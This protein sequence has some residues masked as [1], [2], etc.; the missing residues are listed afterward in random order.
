MAIAAYRP[1]L[2]LS[3]AGAAVA[4]HGHIDPVL[5]AGSPPSSRRP[6]WPGL[7]ISPYRRQRSEARSRCAVR[8][9][10]FKSRISSRLSPFA[11]VVAIA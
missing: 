4:S 3:D 8:G 6:T 7:A 11:S 10:T 9:D 1:D 5:S 2:T